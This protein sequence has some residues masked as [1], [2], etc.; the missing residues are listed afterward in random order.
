MS[1]VGASRHPIP[2][3]TSFWDP[4]QHLTSFSFN[5]CD[6]IRH[7]RPFSFNI[8]NV[9]GYL[10]PYLTFDTFWGDTA[11]HTSA[12]IIMD[13]CFRAGV[14]KGIHHYYTLHRLSVQIEV[15]S[16]CSISKKSWFAYVNL[17][18]FFQTSV[19]YNTFKNELVFASTFFDIYWFLKT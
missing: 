16:R 11:A 13:G 10:R 15:P 9:I 1:K 17:A 14:L 18:W 2:P 12:P 3:L 7:F 8:W 4:F 19:F 6:L 5:I